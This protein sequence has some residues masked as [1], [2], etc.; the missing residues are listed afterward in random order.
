M[1]TF[2]LVFLLLFSNSIWASDSDTSAVRKIAVRGFTNGCQLAVSPSKW[3]KTDWLV[4]GSVAAATAASVAW[5]DKPV[6]DFFF[7][8][9]D[10]TVD[11]IL[12]Q[13]EPMGN[14]YPIAAV[15]GFALHGVVKKNNYSVET[16]LVMAQSMIFNTIAVQSVKRLAG[17]SRPDSSWGADPHNWQGPGNG[18]SFYS[19]HTSTAFAAASVVAWRYRDTKWVPWVAYGMATLGGMQRV[20]HNRHWMSDALFGACTGTAI[21]LFLAKNHETNPLKLYPVITPTGGGLSMVFP[22]GQ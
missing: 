17:R 21:G 20:Y 3:D 4:A 9:Q 18:L 10:K 12:T 14:K 1:R 19:G 2:F 11:K 22:I 13:M 5:F 16:S 8:N 7:D 15:L 6:S